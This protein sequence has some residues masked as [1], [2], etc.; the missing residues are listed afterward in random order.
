MSTRIIFSPLITACISGACTLAA[1]ISANGATPGATWIANGATACEKFLTPEVVAAILA[2]P[3]GAAAQLD[4]TSCHTG[5]IYISLKIV[6]VDTF[7]R[8]LPLIAGTHPLAGVG[9]VAYW[10]GAGAVSA[11][12]GQDRGCN[13]SVIA[14][15][16]IRDE[17][18]GQKL[19]EI[20]S[21]LF[22][23]P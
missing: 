10:N 2:K 21:I 16:K 5:N 20:C 1:S 4:S 7:R 23:L 8:E 22:A 19:G 17:A 13:I 11:V 3:A 15:A 14:G 9:D 12:K 18:L 6:S